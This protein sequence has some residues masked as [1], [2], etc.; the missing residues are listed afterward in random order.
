MQINYSE[1]PV[2]YKDIGK[3]IKRLRRQQKM[4]QEILAE[5]INISPSHMSHIETGQTKASFPTFVHIA[6]A[7]GV[8]INDLTCDNI[9]ASKAVY[10]KEMAELLSD[11]SIEEIRFLCGSVRTLKYEIRKFSN[12]K[13]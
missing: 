9:D 13:K 10:D 8:T 3:R 6:N 1:N 2:N 12:S 5:K 11:C 4:S 7:L